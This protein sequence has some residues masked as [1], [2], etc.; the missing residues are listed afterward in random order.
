MVLVC[1]NA[2]APGVADGGGAAG[3]EVDIDHDCARRALH[4]AR[5]AYYALVERH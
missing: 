2:P 3:G 4:P 1:V 5:G